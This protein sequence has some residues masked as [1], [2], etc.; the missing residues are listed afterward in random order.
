MSWRKPPVLASEIWCT[1][2]FEQ[3]PKTIVDVL[4]DILFQLPACFSLRS[5]WRDL[6]EALD[7]GAGAL[8]E[9]IKAM[10]QDLKSKLDWYWGY[11]GEHL[12]GIKELD[13]S[14]LGNLP[15]IFTVPRKSLTSKS[16]FACPRAFRDT[17]AAQMIAKFSAGSL[18]AY[19]L[20]RSM[21]INNDGFEKEIDA[22]GDSILAAAACHESS[23]PS[24]SGCISM[25]F[26]LRCLVIEAVS[27]VQRAGAQEA[28]NTWG[29]RRGV[30]KICSLQI[31]TPPS[32]RRR[33]PFHYAEQNEIAYT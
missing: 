22:H 2:P 19:G 12:Q 1:V 5:N 23:G 33:L 30:E 8:K 15:S 26:P 9:Q 24:H 25:I 32:D 29:K 20:L 10:S 4:D 16:R 7:P 13:K 31:S 27:D 21:R 17:F 14:E 28:L 3:R 11:Y 6:T 18:I